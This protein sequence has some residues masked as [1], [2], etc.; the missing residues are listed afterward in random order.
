MLFFRENSPLKYEFNQ[1]FSSLFKNAERYISIIREIYGRRSG[2]TRQEIINSG[3]TV[4]GKE[5]TACLEDLEQCGFIRKYRNFSQKINGCHYQLIDPFCLFHLAFLEKDTV[6]SWIEFVNTPAYH[7][8]CGLA[9][10][11]VCLLHTDQIKKALGISGVFTQEFSWRSKN[12]SPGAQVDLLIDRKDDVINVCEI[13]YTQDEYS[14]SASYEKEL[15]QKLEVLRKESKTKKS[16]F[17]TMIS[18]GGI[19]NNAHKNVVTCELTG[20]DLFSP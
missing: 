9:F 7:N 4:S 11:N 14:I 16:L 1:L 18:F 17:L 6:G 8:W 3:N 12:R 20:E 19:K 5:L 13:K 15:I 10:E 2:V